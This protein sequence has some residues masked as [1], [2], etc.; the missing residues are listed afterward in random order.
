MTRRR[1]CE[2]S[3]TQIGEK[4]PRPSGTR[5]RRAGH[6][7]G[8]RPGVLCPRLPPPALLTGGS[9]RRSGSSG[10]TPASRRPRGRGPCTRSSARSDRGLGAVPS[11]LTRAISGTS[12][13][14]GYALWPG[15]VRIPE[16]EPMGAGRH[17]GKRRLDVQADRALTS[18]KGRWFGKAP[19]KHTWL[20]R[21]RRRSPPP[22][23]STPAPRTPL[24]VRGQRPV[25]GRDRARPGTTPPP[26]CRASGPGVIWT[27]SGSRP[28]RAACR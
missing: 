22:G 21:A 2:R 17:L 16:E 28:M 7:A 23:R 3:A 19:G 8:G 4:P 18:A 14:A 5:P 10:P 26:R 20:K 1:R 6:A 11:P 9:K 13:L 27:R 25:R 12:A 15:Q 24:L